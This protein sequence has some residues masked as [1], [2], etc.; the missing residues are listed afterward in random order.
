M[1]L[2]TYIKMCFVCSKHCL[3]M[4]NREEDMFEDVEKVEAVLIPSEQKK[5]D[6]KTG[7]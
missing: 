4:A 3:L 2:K 7:A 5:V 1:P 6:Q